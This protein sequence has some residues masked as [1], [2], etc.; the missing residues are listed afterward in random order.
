MITISQTFQISF[1]LARM[2]GASSCSSRCCCCSSSY[3]SL[4]GGG[5]QWWR[6][7]SKTTAKTIRFGHRFT[8]RLTGAVAIKW[9]GLLGLQLWL[10]LRLFTF[11][12]GGGTYAGAY[13]SC[14]WYDFMVQ[15]LEKKK[16]K[17]RER[18][19][20]LVK[21]CVM[22]VTCAKDSIGKR[23]HDVYAMWLEA[24]PI[25]RSQ[26]SCQAAN[27]GVGCALRC[28]GCSADSRLGHGRL[29]TVDCRLPT[30]FCLEL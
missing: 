24:C 4:A 9:S 15:H 3:V 8:C 10:W 12:F 11:P 7:G 28:S 1:T 5:V 2:C 6:I 17:K 21:W 13:N 23:T 18:K 27:Y 26:W 16:Q 22:F 29:K 20:Q 30:I 14:V 19:S 25:R